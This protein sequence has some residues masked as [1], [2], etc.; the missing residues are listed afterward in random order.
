M[1][2]TPIRG[3]SGS[4]SEEDLKAEGQGVDTRGCKTTSEFLETEAT[5]SGGSEGWGTGVVKKIRGEISRSL[6]TKGVTCL[7]ELGL[8]D[9][10]GRFKKN[11][12][13]Y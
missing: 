9:A 5:W 3:L 11:T 7:H 4:C 1:P 2:L 8:S 13:I 12:Q 6:I 10:W